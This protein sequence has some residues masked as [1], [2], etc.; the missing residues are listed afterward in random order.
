MPHF[1]PTGKIFFISCIFAGMFLLCGS[2]A[3]GEGRIRPSEKKLKLD[4]EYL[5]DS[6][7][8]GRRPGTTGCSNAASYILRR[9]EKLGYEVQVQ[10]FRRDSTIF[11][12]L[13]AFPAGSGANAA[14]RREILV[15][16]SYDGMGTIAGKMYPGADSN[17]SGVAALLSLAE[18]LKGRSNLVFAFVDGHNANSAGAAALKEQLSGR[19]LRMVANIDIIGSTLSP[20]ESAW[21]RYLIILGGSSFEGKLE[22][23]N[24]DMGLHLYYSYY[25]SK[26]FTELFYRKVSDHRFFLGRGIPVLYFTSGITLDTNR[27][28]DT[29]DRLNY[30]VLAMRVELIARLLESM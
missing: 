19:N 5:S 4:A 21:R 6:V 13:V 1:R 2:A 30:P 20:V 12:N 16:C 26:P 7:C 3:A 22:R 27:T 14:Q 28:S 10:S 24:E 15:M 9:M 18:I 23:L 11:R 8:T 25:R 29:A 17:A